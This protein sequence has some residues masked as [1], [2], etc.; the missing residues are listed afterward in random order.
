MQMLGYWQPS[1]YQGNYYDY[2]LGIQDPF[3]RGWAQKDWIETL[4]GRSIRP[5]LEKRMEFIPSGTMVW[6]MLLALSLI[7]AQNSNSKNVC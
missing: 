6:G 3:G 2:W 4:T 1:V 5:V 7:I